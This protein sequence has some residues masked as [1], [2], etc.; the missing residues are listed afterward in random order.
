MLFRREPSTVPLESF[1]VEVTRAFK[2]LP[3]LS[4]RFT[5]RCA[6]L[7]SFILTLY[8][9]WGGTL[10][11][12]GLNAYAREAPPGVRTVPVTLKLPLS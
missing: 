6:F 5:A 9:T 7:E 10:R 2:R 12:T 3:W 4:A 8:G 1:T 11:A